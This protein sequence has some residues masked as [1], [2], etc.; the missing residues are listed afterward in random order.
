M[1]V[2]IIVILKLYYNNGRGTGIL[3]CRENVNNR[4]GITDNT[5]VGKY[6]FTWT[7]KGVTLNFRCLKI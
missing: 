5:P 1:K 3:I 4:G 2:K 6:L 7:T